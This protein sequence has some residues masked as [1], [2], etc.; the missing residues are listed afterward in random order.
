MSHKESLQVFLF[1][2]L[3]Q[4]FVRDLSLQ[5]QERLKTKKA[6]GTLGLTK[7]AA[8]RTGYP[9]PNPQKEALKD[10]K[11]TS[12]AFYTTLMVTA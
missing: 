2:F 5:S 7:M 4:S 6:R 3:F 9:G 8:I 10:Q 12:F 1:Q 11:M